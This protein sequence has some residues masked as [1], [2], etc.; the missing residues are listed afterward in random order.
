MGLSPKISFCSIYEHLAL[1]LELWNL[2]TR[3]RNACRFQISK[4]ICSQRNT[5]QWKFKRC[6][7]VKMLASLSLTPHIESEAVH[8]HYFK[9]RR[10]TATVPIGDPKTLTSPLWVPFLTTTT[11][12]PLAFLLGRYLIATNA[13]PI[14]TCNCH[15]CILGV[16]IGIHTGVDS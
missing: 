8:C 2:V 14:T 11:K 13:I 1:C 12:H 4:P 5:W 9:I 6:R 16:Q 10:Y 15:D 7:L 3:E